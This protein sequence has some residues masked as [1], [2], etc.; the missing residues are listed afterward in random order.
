[1]ANASTS[2]PFDD[3]AQKPDAKDGGKNE[4]KQIQHHVYSLKNERDSS[5]VFLREI[6]ALIFMGV[7]QA[8]AA[9][10]GYV[11]S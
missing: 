10:V 3:E 9:E 6:S 11:A 1:M 7:G 8:N 5:S 2:N 4:P